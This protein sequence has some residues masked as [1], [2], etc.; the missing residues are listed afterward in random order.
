[1]VRIIEVLR[2]F[3]S[4]ETGFVK[5]QNSL[6]LSWTAG[7]MIAAAV[8]LGGPTASGADP[9]EAFHF[10]YS[11]CATTLGCR[12]YWCPQYDHTEGFCHNHKCYCRG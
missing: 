5:Q 9:A 3:V 8:M 2:S 4:D 10:H 1:M 12:N 7:I 6:A 11:P